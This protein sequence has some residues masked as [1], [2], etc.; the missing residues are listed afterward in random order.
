MLNLV[1]KVL[2]I[3]TILFSVNTYA[4]GSF[5]ECELPICTIKNSDFKAILDSFLMNETKCFYYSNKL[6]IWVAFYKKMG[7]HHNQNLIDIEAVP[8]SNLAFGLSNKG[9]CM[10]KNHI[11]LF[12]SDTSSGIYSI[13]KD[14]KKFKYFESNL[15]TML[16][17]PETRWQYYYNIR[18]NRFKLAGKGNCDDDWGKTT[19]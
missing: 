8:D 13:G 9:Y 10:Y 17:G 3:S 6:N 18:K 12:F 1:K 15:P 7:K 16:D 5:K 4:Q 19:H 14:K 11:I 2:L